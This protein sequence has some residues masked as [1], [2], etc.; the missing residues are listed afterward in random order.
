MLL[1]KTDVDLIIAEDAYG[2]DFSSDVAGGLEVHGEYA[3]KDSTESFLGGIRYQSETDLTIIAEYMKTFEASRLLYLKGTQKEP[4][5]LV[6]SSLYVLYIK[7]VDDDFYR[8]QAGGTY[9]FKNGLTIDIALLESDQGHGIK[10]V[11]YYYF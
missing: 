10:G 4:F 1:E 8:I 11:L 3:Y 9:D 6:Y 2:I 5:D 7:D